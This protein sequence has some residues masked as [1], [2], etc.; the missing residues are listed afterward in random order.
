MGA[1]KRRAAPPTQDPDDPLAA[2]LEA[3]QSVLIQG[4]EDAA[5][6]I[7]AVASDGVAGVKGGR[8]QVAAAMYILDRLLGKPTPREHTDDQADRIQSFLSRL[9]TAREASIGGIGGV[10]NAD[11]GAESGGDGNMVG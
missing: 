3:V 6:T 10:G 5:K 4:A 2:T 1:V 7:V 11:L 8:E 9:S